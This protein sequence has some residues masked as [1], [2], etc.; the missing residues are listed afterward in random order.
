MGQQ[1]AGA[2]CR[3]GNQ[4]HPF[5]WLFCIDLF[6]LSGTD[7]KR[8]RGSLGCRESSGGKENPEGGMGLGQFQ[9]SSL[10]ARGEN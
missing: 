7:R 1:C 5:R 10:C 3:E 4:R 8:T 9:G 2:G 6:T